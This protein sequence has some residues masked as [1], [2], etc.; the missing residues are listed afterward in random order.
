M[1]LLENYI[2]SDIK[3]ADRVKL[4]LIEYKYWTLIK[5]C[6]IITS[7]ASLGLSHN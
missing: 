7:S 3:R 4:Y 1:P 5:I 6:R 2:F